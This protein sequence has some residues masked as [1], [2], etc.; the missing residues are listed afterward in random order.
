MASGPHRARPMSW[1]RSRGLAT[2]RER[3]LQPRTFPPSALPLLGGQHHAQGLEHKGVHIRHHVEPLAGR[4][5]RAVASLGLDADE[6]GSPLA[7]R[8]S[9]LQRGDGLEGV[10]GHDPVVPVRGGKHHGRIPQPGLDVV[11]GRVGPERLEVPGVV[12]RAVIG[13]PEMANGE[14]VEAEHVQEAHL[15]EHAAREVRALVG[16]RGDQQAAVGSPLDAEALPGGVPARHE[17]LGA[18]HKIVKH[19]LLAA[20]GARL[21][22]LPAVLAPAADVRERPDAPPRPAAAALVFGEELE[23]REVHRVE[24]GLLDHVEAAVAKQGGRARAVHGAVPGV[25]DEHG[26]LGAVLGRDEL[27]VDHEARGVQARDVRLRH[28]VQGAG[29]RPVAKHRGGREEVLKV[30]EELLVP[31][32]PGDRGDDAHGGEGHAAFHGAVHCALHKLV[33]DVL[34]VFQNELPAHAVRAG[35]V[36]AAPERVLRLGHHGLP[37]G[38]VGEP[39]AR[40]AVPRGPAVGE[41]GPLLPVGGH[42]LPFCVKVVH[43]P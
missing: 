9:G 22:P 36:V 35:R 19:V 3:A 15:A 41:E 14:L 30:E 26:H 4:R 10:Q 38:G 7:L 34:H 1:T 6:D 29:R 5:A 16:H 13:R 40:Q 25:D 43:E 33:L 24:G 31:L 2:R 21:V 12:R 20:A 28:L 11:V 39:H 23:E 17:V 32:A 8:H 42:E 27:L 37:R 18:G